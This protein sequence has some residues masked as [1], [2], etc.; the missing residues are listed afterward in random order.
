MASKSTGVI[1]PYEYKVWF[2]KSKIPMWFLSI[3]RGY[4]SHYS[5]MCIKLYPLGVEFNNNACYNFGTMLYLD[6]NKVKKKT[7]TPQ[8]LNVV[9]G[10]ETCM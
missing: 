7:E 10:T 8:F 2:N 6:N 1:F 3:L 4:L 5:W 9:G